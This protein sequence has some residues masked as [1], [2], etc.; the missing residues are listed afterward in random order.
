MSCENIFGQ[1]VT[2]V[3]SAKGGGGGGAGVVQ[4][5]LIYKIF[6]TWLLKLVGYSDKEKACKFW[7]QIGLY[8]LIINI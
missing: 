2:L 8:V 1:E 4:D 3:L 5:R 6:K 7:K